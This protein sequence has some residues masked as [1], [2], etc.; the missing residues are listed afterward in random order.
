MP[1]IPDE[2]IEIQKRVQAGEH[3]AVTV[4][5]LLSWFW[6]SQRRGRWVASVIREALNALELITFPD[7]NYTFLDNSVAFFRPDKEAKETTPPLEVETPTAPELVTVEVLA[8]LDPT[9]RIERLGI[10]TKAPVSINPD[11]PITEAVTVMLRHDFSQLP[12]MTNEREVK[13]VISWKSL[14]SRLAFGKSCEFVRDAMDRYSEI[15]ADDSLFQAISLLQQH[16]CV[17]VR[18]SAKKIVGILTA[19]DITLTFRQLAEPFLI[20]GEIEN[21][22]RILIDGKF[23]KQELSSVRD[24]EDPSREVESVTNLSLGECV[25]LLEN[26]K[27]WD[28]LGIPVHRATFIKDLDQVRNIRNDVMHFDPEGIGND[29]LR[30]LREFVAFLERVRTLK[31]K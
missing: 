24:P 15:S 23:T 20:L 22:I 31:Q 18:D 8:S 6:G 28:R 30:R 7:F 3:P 5:V 19:Y 13:G 27:Y 4:R 25:R 21:H 16:D 2:L 11:A 14:G 10:A 29:D 1:H 26:P 12:V 9:Y 17:L